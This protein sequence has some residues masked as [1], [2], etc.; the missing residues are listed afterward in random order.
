MICEVID[1]LI[2]AAKDHQ[3]QSME[4][5]S[6]LVKE[7]ADELASVYKELLDVIGV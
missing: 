5:P 4:G 2:D 1:R 3:Y 6:Q 7:S